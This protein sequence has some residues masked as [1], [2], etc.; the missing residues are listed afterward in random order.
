MHISTYYL[1]KK[2][3]KTYLLFWKELYNNIRYKK[4]KIGS[5]EKHDKIFNF[6]K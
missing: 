3:K 2:I 4:N 5:G 6:N 1:Y